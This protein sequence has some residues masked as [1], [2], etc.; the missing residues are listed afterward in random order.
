MSLFKH[1]EP[2][3]ELRGDATRDEIRAT[4]AVAGVMAYNSW[5]LFKSV[6][7]FEYWLELWIAGTDH[8]SSESDRACEA[9]FA[10]RRGLHFT[11]TDNPF[12]GSFSL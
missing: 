9:Y 5:K 12:V 10:S 3:G 4:G 6:K 7:D 2:F 11:D 1:V 8:G